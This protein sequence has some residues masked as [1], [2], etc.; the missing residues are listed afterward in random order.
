M[1]NEFVKDLARAQVDILKTLIEKHFPDTTERAAWI[2]TLNPTYKILDAMTD[3]DPDNKAQLVAIM[4][5]HTA[6]NVIPFASNEFVKVLDRINDEKLR[7]LVEVVSQIPFAVGEIYTDEN[8]AN[9]TQLKTY[10]EAW[11]ESEENQDT[12]LNEVLKPLLSKL[13]KNQAWL[14]NFLI[15][16]IQMRL[17]GANLDI[18]KDG[19]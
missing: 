9:N 4:K 13:F 1:N 6:Q 14:G 10:L 2:L 19:K 11:A 3:S 7:K 12:I 16:T 15:S 17:S 8:P 18:N 5:E